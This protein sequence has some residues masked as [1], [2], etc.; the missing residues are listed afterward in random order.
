MSC[1]IIKS[2]SILDNLA[3]KNVNNARSESIFIIFDE[4]PH[5][6]NSSWCR[7]GQGTLFGRE[8]AR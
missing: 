7:S 8:I 1:P 6:F 2:G 5:F 3:R 4:C